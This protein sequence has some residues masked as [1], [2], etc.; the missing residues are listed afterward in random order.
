[1]E[2][3]RPSVATRWSFV[4]FWLV[5]LLT[6]APSPSTPAEGPPSDP[7]ARIRA[8]LGAFDSVEAERLARL[9]LARTEIAREIGSVEYAR[10]LDL[11]VEALTLGGKSNEDET[12]QLALQAVER[13]KELLPADDPELAGSLLA[14]GE[15]VLRRGDAG[16]AA[17]HIR[18]GLEI[19]EAEGGARDAS[20]I[21]A[22][23]LLGSAL[24]A[25]GDL[26]GA[27]EAYR[28]EGELIDLHSGAASLEAAG[29]AYNTARFMIEVGDW[30]QALGLYRKAARIVEEQ[31]GTKDAR[32][33]YALLGVANALAF[34]GDTTAALET[35]ERALDVVKETMR[36]NHPFIASCHTGVGFAHQKAGDFEAARPAF[37]LALELARDEY[38]PEHEAV[39]RALRLLGG[40]ERK[41][42]EL[43]RAERD[44]A[45]A[46]EILSKSGNEVPALEAR[47]EQARLLADRNRMDRAISELQVVRAATSASIPDHPDAMAW[48]IV[49]GELMLRADRPKESYEVLRA[50][51]DRLAERVGEDYPSYIEGLA[52]LALASA[53]TG[54]SGQALQLATRAES[55]GI[56][57]TRLLIAGLSERQALR[58]AEER[59]SAHDLLLSLAAEG[60]EAARVAAWDAVIR[61]RGAVLDELARRHRALSAVGDTPA[62]NELAGASRRLANLLVHGPS[63]DVEAYR[64]ALEDARRRREEAERALARQ[65]RGFRSIQAERDI[66]LDRIRS[67]LPENGVLI[68]YVAFQHHENEEYGAFVLRPGGAPSFVRLGAADKL[69]TAVDAYRRALQQGIHHTGEQQ[70]TAFREVA[71]NLRALVWDPVSKLVGGAEYVFIVPEGELHLISFATLPRTE[72]GYFLESGRHFHYLS[73]E[74]VLASRRAASGSR[75][76]LIVADPDFNATPEETGGDGATA[77]LFRGGTPRC[78]EFSDIRFERLPRTADEARSLAER[79]VGAGPSTAGSAVSILKGADASELRFK[80]EAAGHRMLHVATHGFFLDGRCASVS[81]ENRG[82][83]GLSSGP[84]SGTPLALSGLVLA[85]ANLRER[86]GPDAEDGIL[87]AQEIASLDLEGTEWV[88]LSACDTALGEVRRG[89]GVFGLRRAFRVGGASTLIMTLWPVRDDVAA[90]WM[91]RLYEARLESGMDT[92]AAVA[93]ATRTVVESRREQGMSTHPAVWGPFVASGDWR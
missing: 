22:W 80:K 26:A 74:R 55:L 61:A 78:R 88:V 30:D 85:G 52:Q 4:G 18:Q 15:V 16:I 5:L 24:L 87:T 57:R 83:G 89:E 37:V 56:D 13:K 64:R 21:P 23:S 42:G 59:T 65:S 75:K 29:H 33:A 76:L 45:E 3:R 47:V 41:L 53:R 50:A 40:V 28:R 84:D 79:W 81:G 10:A 14:L 91:D 93:A 49:L 54:R 46:I 82:I 44:L 38:G 11:L 20:L 12:L 2:T 48:E 73:A 25:D 36:P 71:G 32:Y 86:A 92:A 43:D 17:T 1:M 8:A 77:T 34:L 60:D 7:V 90:A 72:G 68:A 70:E 19:L 66:D 63:G 51:V 39:G 31:S 69:A 27:E 9:H 62:A 35:H 67:A 58:F 6:Q